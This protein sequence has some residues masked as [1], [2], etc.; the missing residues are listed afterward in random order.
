MIVVGLTDRS[1]RF[2]P[3]RSPLTP[4]HAPY[5]RVSSGSLHHRSDRHRHSSF[6]AVW[7]MLT[8]I[9]QSEWTVKYSSERPTLL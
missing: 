1:D 7:A 8:I 2:R 4:R 9:I 3:H 6:D 5:S